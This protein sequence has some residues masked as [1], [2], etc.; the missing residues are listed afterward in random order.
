MLQWMQNLNWEFVIGDLVVPIGL[1]VIG[2]F[3]GEHVEKKKFKA[4]AKVKGSGNTV[5]QNSEIHK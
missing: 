5:I 2:F 3:T 4:K 1:F